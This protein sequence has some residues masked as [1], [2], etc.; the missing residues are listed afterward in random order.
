MQHTI[1]LYL[2]IAAGGC[3]NKTEPSPKYYFVFVSLGDDL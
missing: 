1:Y 2:Y 3:Y